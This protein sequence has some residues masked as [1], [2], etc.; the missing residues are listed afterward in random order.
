M[1]Q[2]SSWHLAKKLTALLLL[3]CTY[4]NSSTTYANPNAD[5]LLSHLEFS[6]Q[7]KQDILSGQLISSTVQ[8]KTEQELAVTLSFKFNKNLNQIR[9][10][11]MLGTVIHKNNDVIDYQ[12]IDSASDFPKLPLTKE[13]LREMEPLL[14]HQAE[15][16]FNLSADEISLFNA[17]GTTE[18]QRHATIRKQLRS[19]LK[20][21]YQAYRS[22]GFS[23]IA[24]YQRDNS[25]NYELG[26]YFI[27]SHQSEF[28]AFSTSFPVFYA[29]LNNYPNN[30]PSNLQER[31]ILLKLSIQGRPAFALEHRI[32]MP[33]NGVMLV[34][35]HYFYVSHTLNGQKFLGVLFPNDEGALAVLLTR[36]TSDAV[37]GFASSS[38][39]FIGRKLLTNKLSEYY[40]SIRQSY[41]QQ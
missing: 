26:N 17:L 39:H 23:A 11:F 24:P 13:N 4:L 37:A 40:H 8:E 25:Q 34:S 35:S 21:R 29:M 12:F 30:K 3:A 32:A 9:D 33:E 14:E 10:I 38:K 7:E 27:H 22:G 16:S 36:A 1:M 20:S 2:K 41:M 28:S 31:F 18:E 6:E 5:D 19:L 15:N